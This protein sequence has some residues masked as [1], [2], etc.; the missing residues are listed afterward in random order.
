M[1]DA[2]EFSFVAI[3]ESLSSA[4]AC[5]RGVL[6][7]HNYADKELDVNIVVGEILQNIIR[8]GFDG[9]SL[10]G[11]FKIRFLLD[12]SNLQIEITDNAPPSDA[13][14][15]NNEHRKPE[16]GGHGLTLV[17]AIADSVSFDMLEKGNRATLRFAF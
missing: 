4:R 15:W 11:Q 7:G 17:N 5:V 13:S 8:Y 3:A 2:G 1:I 16:E 12:G 10:Q 6:Q 9:G 14:H